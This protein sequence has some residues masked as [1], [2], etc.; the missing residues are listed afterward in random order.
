[1][2][3]PAQYVHDNK[4]GDCKAL[5]HY[6]KTLLDIAE[7]P[8]YYTVIYSGDDPPAVKQDSVGIAFNHAVIMIPLD[9]DTIFLECTSASSPMGFA[10]SWL[11]NRKAFIIDGENS[12]LVN[13][14]HYSPK[15]N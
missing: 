3:F 1:K 10:G 13:T 7:V 14:T 6:M 11:G 2:P 15:D 5:S 8:S 4:Y 12:R 9:S